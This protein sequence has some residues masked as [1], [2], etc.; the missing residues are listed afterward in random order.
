MKVKKLI[1]NDQKKKVMNYYS[2]NTYS[3]DDPRIQRM[4]DENAYDEYLRNLN[5]E[6]GD[7]NG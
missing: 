5:Q 6:E 3:I 4:L 7:L 2:Y 1:K